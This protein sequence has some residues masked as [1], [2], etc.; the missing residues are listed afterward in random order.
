MEEME[1]IAEEDPDRHWDLKYRTM[2]KNR[3]FINYHKT[4]APGP[5]VTKTEANPIRFL[6]AH[7]DK[8]TKEFAEV[9]TYRCVEREVEA[10]L[11]HEKDV[12]MD[13]L[14]DMAN[15]ING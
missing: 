15:Q 12:E 5:Y 3:A 10:R 4:V 7:Q 13:A 2:E 14:M 1:K 6:Y 8:E 9:Y 11:P